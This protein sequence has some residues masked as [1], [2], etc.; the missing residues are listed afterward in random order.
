MTLSAAA[1]VPVSASEFPPGCRPTGSGSPAVSPAGRWGAA[2]RGGAG[3]ALGAAGGA[4]RVSPPR[5]A[6]TAPPDPR[7]AGRGPTWHRVPAGLSA[8]WAACREPGKS[9]RVL[10]K[11]PLRSGRGTRGL[12]SAAA[13][14]F[15]GGG[16]PSP[17]EAGGVGGGAGPRV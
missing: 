3:R 4:A 7:A 17:A 14:C 16:G 6:L 1:R 2:L 15:V 5:A 11:V 9:R 12:P 8:P 13:S 10:G